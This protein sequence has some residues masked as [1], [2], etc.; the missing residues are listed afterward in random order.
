MGRLIT[1]EQTDKI[2]GGKDSTK[3]EKGPIDGGPD[4]PER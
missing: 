1:E 2:D 3:T 4:K